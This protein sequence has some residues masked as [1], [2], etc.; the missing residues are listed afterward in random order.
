ME[1]LHQP[2]LRASDCTGID[3]KGLKAK[4]KDSSFRP[5]PFVISL[6]PTLI[7]TNRG[8]AIRA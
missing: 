4:K 7:G 6:A 8:A 1:N 2:Q 5:N 3:R